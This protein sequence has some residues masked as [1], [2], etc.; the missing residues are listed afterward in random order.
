ML[1]GK[2]A[3]SLVKMIKALHAKSEPRRQPQKPKPRERIASEKTIETTRL[4]GLQAERHFASLSE[5][6][7]EA[8]LRG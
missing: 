8:L 2:G 3:M 1:L 5:K 6:E 4:T 7:Q